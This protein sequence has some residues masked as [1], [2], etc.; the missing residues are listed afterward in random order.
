[1]ESIKKGDVFWV[2]FDPTL[3]AEAKKI[4]PALVVSN[5]INNENSPIISIAPVT[6]NVTRVYL[7]EVEL[8]AGTANLTSRSKVMLN[9]TRAIDKVRLGP[10]MGH[11]SDTLM[12]QVDE[13]LKLHYDLG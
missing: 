7:F 5:N 12:E 11:L 6:S 8:P 2:N 3:G 13:A 9:Q 1:M 4:R 10:F